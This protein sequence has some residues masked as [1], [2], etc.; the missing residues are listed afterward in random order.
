MAQD[1]VQL[2]KSADLSVWK[3]NQGLER[4]VAEKVAKLEDNRLIA[5]NIAEDAA[6]AHQQAEESNQQLEEAIA[7]AN[8]MALEA[9]LANAAKS[10]FLANMSHEIRTPMNGV[11]S[12]ASLLLTTELTEE[13]KDYA[14]T[15]T[16]SA[17]ALLVIINDI[18]DFSKI[19]A[20]KIEMEE[21][22]FDLRTTLDDINDSIGIRVQEKGLEYAGY[23]DPFIPSL[24]RGDPGRLRQILVNLLGNA[25][26]FTEKGE[27]VLEVE[28]KKEEDEEATLFF[29]VR[30]T[31]IGIKESQQE[32]LF[33]AFTQADASTTRHYG[34]TGLGLA[35]SKRLVEMM[36]GTIG[37]KSKEGEGARFWFTAKF[38][39][40][41]E[42]TA[43]WSGPDDKDLLGVKV[44]IVDDNKVNLK[45]LDSYLSAWGMECSQAENGEAALEM[46]HK[47]HKEG[48]PF[49]LALLD[50]NMPG[51][52]GEDLGRQIKADPLLKKIHLAMVTSLARRGDAAMLK[53]IGFEAYLTKPVKRSQ[54]QECL[55]TL[56]GR[57]PKKDAQT[58]Q[59]DLVTRHTIMENRKRGLK[60]LVVEDNKTNQ[61]VAL[62]LLNR[63]GY[64]ADICSNGREA[65]DVLEKK[66]YD[67]VFMDVQMPVMDGFTAT[68]KIR[69]PQSKVLDHMVPVIAMTAHAMKGDR[70]RCLEAG[71]NG[72]VP[73]PVR[74]EDIVKAISDIL[75]RD[76]SD[77]N[78]P[79]V[80]QG[81]EVDLGGE[82]KMVDAEHLQE[83]FGDTLGMLIE[84]FEE[85]SELRLKEIEKAV[86]EQNAALLA[87][88]A[89]ALKGIV[90]NFETDETFQTALTLE[91]MGRKEQLDGS[92]ELFNK[93]QDMV[94][95]L[96]ESLAE[97]A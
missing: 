37:V 85:E 88:S 16:R 41:S 25:I 24:L 67:L 38:K 8:Q 22:D 46:L 72:Y 36:N 47:A 14:K 48:K 71:M 76:Y 21:I 3:R 23:I 75:N 86:Q 10:E 26:K 64:G 42:K 77:I 57:A 35:I 15:I 65:L 95:D 73:K 2:F 33:D 74:P 60:I 45:V 6:L 90:G 61:K 78:Q 79:P 91:Q 40:Q 44:L 55:A 92:V 63:L 97:L 31:G 30:D 50:M 83:K 39:K 49:S 4:M 17:D 94:S 27:I 93:L 89:H 29:E 62:A 56:M 9:E 59:A 66:N 34:G 58:G 28:L 96:K 32:M 7:R 84:I 19:E 18:L 81:P 1:L 54:L 5:L 80:S 20:G 43:S 12:M 52:N 87:E 53:K 70:E 13:Q 69:D 51:M 68:R 82:E 11:V